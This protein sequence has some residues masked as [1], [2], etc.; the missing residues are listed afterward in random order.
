M[1]LMGS[2]RNQD[3]E[4]SLGSDR[5]DSLVSGYRIW[6]LF[7]PNGGFVQGW[8]MIKGVHFRMFMTVRPS[9]DSKILSCN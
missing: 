8:D 4:D 2:S 1:S 7:G 9:Y 6:S 5:R 3:Q